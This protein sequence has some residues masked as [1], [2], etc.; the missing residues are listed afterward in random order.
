LYHP[1]VSAGHWSTA[2]SNHNLGLKFMINEYLYSTD[3][4]PSLHL[5]HQPHI[6]LFE[7]L[8]KQTI[9]FQICKGVSEIEIP[10]AGVGVD[11]AVY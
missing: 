10:S 3:E 4:Y 8:F 6:G 2:R 9:Q 1:N 11:A 7:H 5:I